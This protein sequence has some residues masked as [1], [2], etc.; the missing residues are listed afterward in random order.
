MTEKKKNRKLNLKK[1]RSFLWNKFLANEWMSDRADEAS[2][3]KKTMIVPAFYRVSHAWSPEIDSTALFH[4]YEL[5]SWY[6]IPFN[7][8]VGWLIL[9]SLFLSRSIHCHDSLVKWFSCY[10]TTIR[11]RWHTFRG[12]TII[13]IPV[14][15]SWIIKT[16]LSARHQGCKLPTRHEISFKSLIT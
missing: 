11:K 13:I 15:Y 10:L 3:V 12:G 7:S 8:H 1:T 5:P 9:L 2:K 14:A 16:D 6:E 4:G